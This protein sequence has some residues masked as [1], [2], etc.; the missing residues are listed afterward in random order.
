VRVSPRNAVLID[1]RNVLRSRWP[2][3]GEQ[4]LVDLCRAWGAAHGHPVVLVFDG[5]AP[6]G[7]VGVKELDEICAV[8]GSGPESA[9][10]WIARR[11]AELAAAGEPYWLVTSD[12]ELRERARHD[13]RRTVGGGRFLRE[14]GVTPGSGGSRG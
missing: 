11:A 1:A 10:D 4:E 2:N 3:L 14:L 5:R 12:R 8:V 7:V 9:D 13:A 6:G